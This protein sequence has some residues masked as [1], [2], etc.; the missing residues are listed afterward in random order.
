MRC[1]ATER[2]LRAA[3]T[4]DANARQLRLDCC[5]SIRA[6]IP[7]GGRVPVPIDS[8]CSASEAPSAIFAS[9]AN[10]CGENVLLRCVQ[11]LYVVFHVQAALQRLRVNARV[12]RRAADLDV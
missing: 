9:S 8:R 4:F 6:I 11:F 1:A 3:A 2:G 10:S 7:G 5:A 12:E